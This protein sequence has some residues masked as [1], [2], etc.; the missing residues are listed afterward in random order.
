LL[1]IG[2]AW[3]AGTQAG[4]RQ[5][6]RTSARS[7]YWGGDRN[8]TRRRR[9]IAGF[10]AVALAL[11]TA[12]PVFGYWQ[13]VTHTVQIAGPTGTLHA[14]VSYLMRA[15]IYDAN[16]ERIEGQPVSWRIL[17]GPTTQALVVQAVPKDRI[18]P[19]TKVT[20]V[21]GQVSARIT[22]AAVPGT[23]VITATADGVAGRLV[24]NLTAAGLPNTSTLQP[25]APSAPITGTL[26]AMLAIALGGAF[27][28][29]Q[30][31]V[32]RR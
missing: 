28:L 19:L 20:N 30:L 4:D 8:M 21:H 6:S 3:L 7:A 12:A 31:A 24:L 18:S 11:V 9:G 13:Q 1:L 16:G 17:S 2:G 32:N 5:V 23:R 25:A 29:R 10:A 22:L 27:V 15:T 26:L 14:G